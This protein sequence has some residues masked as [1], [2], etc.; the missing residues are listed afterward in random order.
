[1]LNYVLF[2]LPSMEKHTFPGLCAFV[3]RLDD[4]QT[5]QRLFPRD[6]RLFLLSHDP[7]EMPCHSPLMCGVRRFAR[8]Y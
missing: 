6:D 5:R 4:S 3:D 1:M 8:G 7:A 2:R